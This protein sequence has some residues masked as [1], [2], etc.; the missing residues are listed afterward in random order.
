MS[1]AGSG[2]EELAGFKEAMLAHARPLTDQSRSEDL[3]VSKDD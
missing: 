3:T 1:R 2:A